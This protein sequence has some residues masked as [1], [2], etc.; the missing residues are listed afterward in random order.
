MRHAL[1]ERVELAEGVADPGLQPVGHEQAR[2]V[3]DWLLHEEVDRVVASPKRRAVET[4]TPLADKLGKPVETL[5]G[6]TELDKA[7]THY[8][9]VEEMRRENNALW[10]ALLRGDW[11]AVGYQDPFEFR[12][13]VVAEIDRLVAERPDERVAVFAHSGT[14]N[15]VV[16]HVLGLERVFLFSPY[17]TSISR[18]HTNPH[19]GRLA[20]GSLN[21]TAHLHSARRTLDPL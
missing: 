2:R 6:L 12:L 21:E 15:A 20:V 17:Y 4:A 1:P 8:I 7:S 9:P 13:E 16:S 5:V 19:T 14:I 10:Q 18:L 11:A 3:A